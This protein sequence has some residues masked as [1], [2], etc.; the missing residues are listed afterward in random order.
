MLSVRVVV[1]KNISVVITFVICLNE[2]FINFISQNIETNKTPFTSQHNIHDTVIENYENIYCQF[3]IS[4]PLQ[5]FQE[6][7]SVPESDITMDLW[8]MCLLLD[9]ILLEVFPELGCNFSVR[10]HI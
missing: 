4:F 6:S 8:I 5:S 2:A 3:W 10:R 9:Q 1:N 7:A